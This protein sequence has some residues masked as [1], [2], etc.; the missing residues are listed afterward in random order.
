MRSSRLAPTPDSSE[1]GPAAADLGEFALLERFRGALPSPPEGEIWSGDDAAV[2]A[3]GSGKVVITTD[4]LV[5]GVDFDLSYTPG[6]DVGWKAMAANV[7]DLAAMAASPGSAVVA[8]G[9]PP[10][11]P[12]SLIDGILEGLRSA[13]ERWSVDLV[14]GDVSEAPV[15]S[16]AVALLGWAERPV[17]RSG[18]VAGD[19]ICV[20]GTLGGAAG[21]LEALRRGLSGVAAGALV[22]RQLRPDARLDEGRALA[23][24][25]SVTAMIDVSDGLV[26]DLGHLL[27]ASGVG[28]DVDPS[29]IP[30]DPALHE[31]G[32]EADPLELALTGGEDLELLFTISAD[33]FEALR[34][35]AV[36][37]TRIGIVTESGATIGGRS[38]DAW[39]DKG[40]EH[41]RG[42]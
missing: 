40:W 25:G 33:A 5:E 20:T 36:G 42:R 8:L 34:S 27:S 16:L 28:C 13:G 12:V 31:A 2:V 4:M 17:L 41:L 30:I 24:T 9:L 32:L 6:V 11:T 26:R 10:A 19:A 37:V 1:Q 3:P 23:A 38:L 39:K 14:G 29:L 21:G 35:P 15:L 22:R 18:A 7:S